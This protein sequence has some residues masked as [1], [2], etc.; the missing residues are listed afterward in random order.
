[1]QLNKV[2]IVSKGCQ[3]GS[4]DGYVRIQVKPTANTILDGTSSK[5][6]TRKIAYVGTMIGCIKLCCVSRGHLTDQACHSCYHLISHSFCS[7]TPDAGNNCAAA[8]SVD[9]GYVWAI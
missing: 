5:K 4:G 1:M 8:A 7:L 9:S 6:I 2:M 3:L